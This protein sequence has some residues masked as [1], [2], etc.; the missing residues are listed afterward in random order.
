VAVDEIIDRLY[1]L[2]LEEFTQA[3]NEAA[4]ELRNEGRRA[5]AERI[6]AL[7][8]PTAAAAAVNRLVREHRADVEAF[9]DAAAKLRDAQFGGQGDVASA[10]RRERE[11]LG[12]LTRVA[13]DVVRQTLQAAAVDE[14]AARQL[15]E[16]RL[17]R[18]LE[19]RGFGTLLA[20]TGS[21]SARRTTAKRP[22]A[23]RKPDDRAAR[24]KLRDAK[25]ELAAAEAEER[26]AQRRWTQTR[27]ELEKAQA[28]VE[29][30]ERELE[31]LHK[32]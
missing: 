2:P 29:K 25:E 15:L 4:V 31:E 18:E 27:R 5:E 6:K 13:G 3:R 8:K 12:R 16:G 1:G 20:Q 23:K 22:P 7:R 14:E 24:A 19:P 11:A 9:L 30:A 26:Q 21:T 10:T 17:E 32:R 28:A